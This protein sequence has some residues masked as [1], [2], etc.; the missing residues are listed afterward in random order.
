MIV[1][2]TCSDLTDFSII[3]IAAAAHPP[4]TAT[5]AAWWI[6]SGRRRILWRTEDSVSLRERA[7]CSPAEPVSTL[8]SSSLELL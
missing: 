1:V 5:A 3:G 7:A 2:R 4:A 6:A 8:S